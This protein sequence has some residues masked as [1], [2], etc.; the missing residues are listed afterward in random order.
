MKLTDLKGHEAFKM[1]TVI[2]DENR[3][4]SGMECC[5]LLSWVMANGKEDE[6]WITVQIHAN[7]VAVA[8]LLD[9]SCIIIPERIKVDDEVIQKAKEEGLT[10]FST[11]LDAY[12]IFKVF[13]DQTEA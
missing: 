1:L 10:I 7:I 8:T 3:Q 9:F 5:D 4:I 13:H 2:E 6:A 12:G 11:A